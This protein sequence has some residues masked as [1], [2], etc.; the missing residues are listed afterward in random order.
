MIGYS[1]VFELHY[2]QQDWDLFRELLRYQLTFCQENVRHKVS[3]RNCC[4]NFVVFAE[5]QWGDVLTFVYV[6]KKV[7]LLSDLKLEKDFIH[8]MTRQL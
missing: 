6:Y 4:T 7:I 1:G 2:S 3:L 5:T 8:V